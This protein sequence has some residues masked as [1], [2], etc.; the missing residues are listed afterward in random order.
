MPAESRLR[1]GVSVVCYSLSYVS[2]SESGVSV[3]GSID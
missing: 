1:I 3:G 2:L